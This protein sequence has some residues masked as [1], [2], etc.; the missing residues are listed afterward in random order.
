MH[1]QPGLPKQLWNDHEACA[2]PLLVSFLDHFGPE[3]AQWTA[4]TIHME[5]HAELGSEVPAPVY[6]RLMAALAIR[7][8]NSFFKSMPDFITLILGLCGEAPT[9]VADAAQCAWGLT[10]ALLI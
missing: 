6:R 4:L 5:L 3:A 8:S 1:P 9:T 7:Q 10:E 2:T